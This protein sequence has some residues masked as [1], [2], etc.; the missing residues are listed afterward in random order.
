MIAAAVLLWSLRE[1]LLLLFAAVVLAMAL[2]TLVGIVRERRPMDRSLALL[3]CLGGLLTI[4]TVILTVVIPPFLEEFAVLLQ[5]LPKAAQ[6]LLGLVMDW[7]DGISQAIYG[8][9][10]LSNLDELGVSD[11]SKLVPDGQSIAAG[12]GS[13]ALGLLGLAGNLGNA[14]LRLLFVIAVALMVSVQPQAY[15]GCL[16]YTSPSP[17]DLSTSRMPSSA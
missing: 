6:T 10:S 3:L 15:R 13:G 14:L 8:I 7:I 4:F 2:C 16:L 12:L 1:V 17:R 5:Q 11:P 9:D